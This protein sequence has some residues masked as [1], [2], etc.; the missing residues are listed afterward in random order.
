MVIVAEKGRA[1]LS[2]ASRVRNSSTYA[3]VLPSRFK[4]IPQSVIRD[5]VWRAVTEKGKISSW[6]HYPDNGRS[7]EVQSAIL[8]SLLST[9][10]ATTT[11][12]LSPSS[13]LRCL[14]SRRLPH[15]KPYRTAYH[16]H[17]PFSHPSNPSRPADA[18]II[19]AKLCP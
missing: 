19:A 8:H 4:G 17:V 1:C 6:L 2:Q 13:F 11:F 16:H 15:R 7:H 18:R 14:F 9:S 12:S 3:Y 5:I 10:N